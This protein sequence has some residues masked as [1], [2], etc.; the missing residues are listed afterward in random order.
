MSNGVFYAYIHNIRDDNTARVVITFASRAVA[1]EW[2]RS[3][4]GIGYNIKRITPQFYTHDTDRANV[5]YF[6]VD[7]PF[8]S[9]AEQFRG[10]MF[11]TLQN[12]RGGRGI[13]I[14]PPRSVGDYVSGSLFDPWATRICIGFTIHP[15]DTSVPPTER[16]HFQIMANNM[17]RGTVMISTDPITIHIDEKHMVHVDADS[18]YLVTEKQRY[19]F[20][21]GSLLSGVLVSTGGV[22]TYTK[23]DTSSNELWELV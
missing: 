22:L 1:D 18:A 9:I 23:V 2:W 7:A 19:D 3:I 15:V 12:D 13:D 14:I 17:P 4:S 10:R 16:T 6:F 5:L 8:K 20:N 11:L 21:F